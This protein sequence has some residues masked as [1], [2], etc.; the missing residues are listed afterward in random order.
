[1]SERIITSQELALYPNC[2]CVIVS[3]DGNGEL[4]K[5]PSNIEG[6][7][8]VLNKVISDRSYFDPQQIKPI[9]RTLSSMTKEEATELYLII[10][11]TNRFNGKIAV[12]A[13]S[14][15]EGVYL[16]MFV[17]KT[18]NG[19]TSVENIIDVITID[20]AFNVTDEYGSFFNMVKCVDWARRKCFDIDDLIK[21]GFAY[22][23]GW[24]CCV[25]SEKPY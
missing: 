1:M 15:N 16:K 11:D 18:N 17:Y 14:D 5:T 10:S 22:T 20:N 2:S 24:S 25:E 9:L 21:N 13:F 4:V 12:D 23:H 7:D 19:D 8:F 3:V 6:F